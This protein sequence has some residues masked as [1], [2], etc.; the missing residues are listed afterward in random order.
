M[1]H[2][3]DC[4]FVWLSMLYIFCSS[5]GSTFF[6]PR[7]IPAELNG[8]PGV[9]GRI[10]GVKTDL[11][12]AN[13]FKLWYTCTMPPDGSDYLNLFT[14][15]FSQ[16]MAPYLT[17][18]L[19]FDWSQVLSFLCA[20]SENMDKN[21]FV[22]WLNLKRVASISKKSCLLLFSLVWIKIQRKSQKSFYCGYCTGPPFRHDF[23]L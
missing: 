7:S 13:V 19:V 5:G 21:K 14:A 10:S 15:W 11:N 20:V 9:W 4:P 17:F 18:F 2:W 6:T 23:F 22:C 16:A 12:R 1:S 8:V 3:T